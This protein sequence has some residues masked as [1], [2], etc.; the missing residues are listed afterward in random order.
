VES[1]GGVQKKAESPINPK[2]HQS[3]AHLICV[4]FERRNEGGILVGKCDLIGEF[5]D[6][7]EAETQRGRCAGWMDFW[8]S[9]WVGGSPGQLVLIRAESA[10]P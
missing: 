4:G 1:R 6:F 7:G 9:G 8:M 10:T 3:D 5:A 2:I